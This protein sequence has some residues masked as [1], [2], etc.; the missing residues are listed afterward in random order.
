MPTTGSKGENKKPD[1]L[2]S[3][4]S[5]VYDKAYKQALNNFANDASKAANVAMNAVRRARM[6]KQERPGFAIVAEIQKTVPEEQLVFGWSY[7]SDKGDSIDV[8]DHS[9][10]SMEIAELEKAAYGFNLLEKR[11]TGE[12][13]LKADL[14][15]LVESM[16]FT[17][18]KYAAMGIEP[19]GR[20]LGWWVGFKVKDSELW[21]GIKEGKFS[22]FSIEGSAVREAIADDAA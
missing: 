10:E 22:M 4:E 16:V 19:E 17:K 6:K 13:H 14:G 12:M 5:A 20:P 9:G 21:K 3:G 1:N 15:D 11:S 8:V 18:E 2:S 7:V